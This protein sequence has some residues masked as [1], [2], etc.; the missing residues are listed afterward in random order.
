[1]WNTKANRVAHP[2][3]RSAALCVAEIQ[4]INRLI[5]VERHRRIG[6]EIERVKIRRVSAGR[7]QR[8]AGPVGLVRP[9]ARRV[10]AGNLRPSKI[11]GAGGQQGGREQK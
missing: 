8:G 6:R 10:A 11:R 1:M 9:T 2:A 4:R 5:A 3:S 7:R